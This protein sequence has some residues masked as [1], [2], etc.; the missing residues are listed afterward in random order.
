M[1]SNTT[2]RSFSPQRFASEKLEPRRLLSAGDLDL[3]FGTGGVTAIEPAGLR[4]GSVAVLPDDRIVVLATDPADVNSPLVVRR[5]TS[6][7]EVDTTFGGGDGQV[8]FALQDDLAP[9]FS[10]GGGSIT[11]LS[12]GKLLVAASITQTA[13]PQGED[14]VPVPYLARLTADGTIDSTFGDG[15]VIQLRS[16][17]FLNDLVVQSDGK[18]LI[19]GTDAPTGESAFIL[20]RNSDGSADTGFGT[21]DGMF[22]FPGGTGTYPTALQWQPDGKILA[23]GYLDVVQAANVFVQRINS[24]GSTD[25]TFGNQGQARADVPG[26]S[27]EYPTGSVVLADGKLRIA[28]AYERG[29][30]SGLT[31]L[32]LNSDGTLDS[33]FGDN[34]LS[35]TG[36]GLGTPVSPT[37]NLAL[38]GAGRLLV[39]GS[40]NTFE[41]VPRNG[42]IAGARLDAAT[43]TLDDD[44]GRV[45]LGDGQTIAFAP[46]G[47]AFQ[48][49]GAVIVLAGAVDPAAQP[50]PTRAELP[51]QLRR[52]L[53]AG[54]EP[55]P[56]ALSNGTLSITGGA[57]DDVVS[58]MPG[59]TTGGATPTTTAS[60]NGFGRVFDTADVSL[61][62]VLGNAG[63][64]IVDLSRIALRATVSGGDGADRIA[65]GSGKDSLSGN[66]GKDQISGGGDNDRLAGNGGRD[67]LSGG[68]GEDRL[69]GGV[70]DD[71]LAGQEDDDTLVGDQGDD[72]IDARFGNDFAHGNA[73]DDIFFAAGDFTIDSLFG[74]GGRDSAAADD[75]DIR[76]S[77][78]GL[79][80]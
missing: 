25:T 43:G 68:D 54:S 30:A 27:G 14:Y 8:G 37:R 63:D 28:I 60:V 75:D 64:D 42:Q 4:A 33:S 22:F 13:V 19:L 10:T 35:V 72:L 39:F 9:G 26:I 77:I 55:S 48:S 40:A 78:E 20:R 80:V 44:F 59:D 61:V 53:P 29:D 58:A 21:G 70:G 56:V 23:I 46:E 36:F 52:L 73:G 24:D 50:L 71:W 1:S 74:D 11:P 38:D 31:V 5:Y 47:F 6:G 34:G 65:G 69:Y 17:T 32:G 3:A 16:S 7:G 18:I 41:P 76:T 51:S 2:S 67:K 49:D 66:A 62:S 12:D 15:G 57:G 45:L 79:I